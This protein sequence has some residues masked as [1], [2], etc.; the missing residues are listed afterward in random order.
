MPQYML[1]LHDDPQSEGWKQSPEE[2]QRV[3]EKYAKWRNSPFVFDGRRLDEQTGRVIRKATGSVSITDGP[4]S[5]SREVLG[6]YYAINAESFEHAVELVRNHPH[7]DFGS[8]EI[9]EMISPSVQ[10]AKTDG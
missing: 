8:I 7:L 10:V 5:E 2:L 4:Y 3:F 1:L 9:R 6:G